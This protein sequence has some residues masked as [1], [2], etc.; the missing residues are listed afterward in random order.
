MSLERTSAQLRRVLFEGAAA[1]GDGDG[2]RDSAHA[3][4]GRF[5]AETQLV[6]GL[7]Q[8][9]KTAVLKAPD[10]K[11]LVSN[12]MPLGADGKPLSLECVPLR[13]G[14]QDGSGAAVWL[15]KG[16]GVGQLGAR[17]GPPCLLCRT[18]AGPPTPRVSRAALG[19][20]GTPCSPNP[21]HCSPPALYYKHSVC[22]T[23]AAWCTCVMARGVLGPKGPQAHPNGQGGREATGAAVR[24]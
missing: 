4:S 16:A 6:S 5:V 2:A 22:V 9:R 13:C 8:P 24:G 23:C 19:R 7:L 11:E 10:G 14:G 12:K 18:S 3:R 21:P 20:A 17:P 15:M 1:D